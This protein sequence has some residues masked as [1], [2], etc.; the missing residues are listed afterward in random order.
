MDSSIKLFSKPFR[1]AVIACLG[2][3]FIA[4]GFCIYNRPGQSLYLFPALIP[5]LKIKIRLLL[6]TLLHTMVYREM[7]LPRARIF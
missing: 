2:G 1:N 3:L 5:I 6:K 7:N 4:L